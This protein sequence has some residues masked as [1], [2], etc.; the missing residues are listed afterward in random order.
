MGAGQMRL[1]NLSEPFGPM[2]FHVDGSATPDLV[3]QPFGGSGWRV[4][5]EGPHTFLAT[6]MGDMPDS[7]DPTAELEVMNNGRYTLS[8]Y[9]PPDAP[10]LAAEEDDV[11]GVAMG[12]LRY[13]FGHVAIGADPIDLLDMATGDPV[14]SDLEYG[15][16]AVV[17]R[18]PA[19]L[20]LGVDLQRDGVA[21]LGFVLEGLPPGVLVPVWFALSGSDLV[22]VGYAPQGSVTVSFGTPL[23]GGSTGDT[24]T[25]TSFTGST[26]GTGLGY[27][28]T[29][30]TGMP[31][32]AT[33]GTGMP[34]LPTGGTGAPASTGGTAN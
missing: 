11:G 12:E 31:V 8:L 33:G 14:V 4:V 21:D 17:D 1:V 32:Q 30:G 34:G 27:L 20:A 29:G 22:L 5:F 25:T 28:P 13:R 16:T 9:G 3:L 10:V 7:A 24:G 18:T 2:A 26:G 23:G 19:P 15:E 6:P